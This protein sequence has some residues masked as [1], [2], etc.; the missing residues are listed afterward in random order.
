[1]LVQ[2]AKKYSRLAPLPAEARDDQLDHRIQEDARILIEMFETR[3]EAS[4][5]CKSKET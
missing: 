1:M 3:K 5:V 2:L 4:E